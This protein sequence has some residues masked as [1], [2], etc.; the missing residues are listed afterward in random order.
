MATKLRIAAKI[1]EC[2]QDTKAAV[3]GCMLFLKGLHNLPAIGETFST[4][5]KGG[6]KS[7]VFK[8]SRL[9]IVKSVLSL[10]FGI[11]KFIAAR[12][13]SE[14]HDVTNWPGIPLPTKGKAELIHPLVIYP[15]TVKEIFDKEEL[16]ENQL[17]YIHHM[18][19][20]RVDPEADCL[21]G[22]T[23]CLKHT[24]TEHKMRS[25]KR[26]HYRVKCSGIR[27]GVI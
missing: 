19:T 15:F 1:L 9:E 23:L 27:Y 13:S 25:I 14:L 8:D 26:F 10:N 16:L 11:S 4:Y 20:Q 18:S 6:I 7:W 22:K 17:N 5:Y 2:L 21:R 3:A 12:F 24:N